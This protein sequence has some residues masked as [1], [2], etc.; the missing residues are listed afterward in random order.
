MSWGQVPGYVMGALG[1]GL[2]LRGQYNDTRNYNDQISRFLSPSNVAWRAGV[3]NPYITNA[4]QGNYGNNAFQGDLT[5][6]AQGQNISPY[7]L[8]QPLNQLNQGYAQN[9]A[10]FQSMVGRNGGGGGLSQAY[11]LANL[12]GRNNTIANLYNQY[13]QYREQQ[14]RQ[15]INNLLGL[16]QG[17]LGL[18]SQL[19]GQKANMFMQPQSRSSR[20]GS[21]FGSIATMFGAGGSGGGANPI[22]GAGGGFNPS[23]FGQGSTYTPFVSSLG[24]S[25]NWYQGAPPLN[26]IN[27]NTAP[28]QQGMSGL[29]S[30]GASTP[31]WFQ[32]K[33]GTL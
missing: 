20:L 29:A 30:Y 26:S 27:I 32:W 12:G 2:S 6:I 5:R 11:A 31:P 7:L 25:G 17:N 3:L 1:S 9:L 13:G 24:S 23:S 15:D 28:Q 22:G 4:M 19:Q 14:R 8:N 21:Y 18:A 10:R 16:Y 33:G